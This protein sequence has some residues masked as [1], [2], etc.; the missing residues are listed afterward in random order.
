MVFLRSTHFSL[1]IVVAR[2]PHFLQRDQPVQIAKAVVYRR[3]ARLAVRNALLLH[4]FLLR[5][6]YIKLG[7]AVVSDPFRLQN[8]P[9][10]RPLLDVLL[11]HLP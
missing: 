7:P 11:K 6:F 8:I 4:S 10:L 2:L 1:D 9:H 3:H 5:Q